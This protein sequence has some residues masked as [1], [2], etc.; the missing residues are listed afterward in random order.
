MGAPIVVGAGIREPDGAYNV[1]LAWDPV[2]GP[3]EVYAKRHPVPFAEYLP[4]R[5]LVLPAAWALVPGHESIAL[6]GDSEGWGAGQEPGV[7]TVGPAVIGTV[8]CFEVAYDGLVRDLVDGGANVVVVPTNKPMVRGTGQIEQQFAMSRVRAVETGR[9]VVVASTNGI[10]G[11][12]A[13]DGS[14]VERAPQRTT[15]VIEESVQLRSAVLPAVRLGEWLE[16][17]LAGLAVLATG[18]ALVGYRRRS[19]VAPPEKVHEHS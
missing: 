3:G 6:L 1:A 4:L 13:P 15:A 14:V 9:Y 11:V 5:P 17:G 8:I 18:A 12:I 2:T 19:P 10:S 16:W 7:L